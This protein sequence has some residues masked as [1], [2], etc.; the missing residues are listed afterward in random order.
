MGADGRK[1]DYFVTGIGTGGTI[2]GVA[3]FLKE[4]DSNI[5]VIG[6]DPVGSVFFDYFYSKKLVKPSPYLLEGLGDEFLIDCVDF[7]LIDDIYQITDKDAFLM[8]RKL[9]DKEAILAGG[10]SGAVI[11]ASLKLAREID[12]PARI[13]TIFADSA[14]R[15]LN[16][17]YNDEWLREKGIL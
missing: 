8:T 10:S 11:W 6:V 14:T 4:K 7:S 16:S 12:R 17:I 5:Q 13:V 3:K 1:I 15:Y 9:A 2:S